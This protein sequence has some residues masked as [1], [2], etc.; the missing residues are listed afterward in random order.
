M[1]GNP[2]VAFKDGLQNEL[3]RSRHLGDLPQTVAEI[4]ERRAN[5]KTETTTIPE[6]DRVG[7]AGAMPAQKP[8]SSS[9]LQ[10]PESTRSQDPLLCRPQTCFRADATDFESLCRFLNHP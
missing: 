3:A 8:P 5:Q 1:T 6:V 10:A 4:P 2:E 9:A 7:S